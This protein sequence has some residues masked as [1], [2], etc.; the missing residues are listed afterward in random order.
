[1][2][3]FISPA[4]GTSECNAESRTCADE[5]H[6]PDPRS[7]V[8]RRSQLQRDECSRNGNGK[9]LDT[10]KADTFGLVNGELM[11]VDYGWLHPAKA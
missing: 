2:P 1:M 10:G 8:E 6:K 5:P 7:L 4:L 3:D 9:K 11:V